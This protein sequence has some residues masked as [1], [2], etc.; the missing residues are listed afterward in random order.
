MRAE[1]KHKV[2][3]N[4]THMFIYGMHGCDG[5]CGLGGDFDCRSHDIFIKDFAAPAALCG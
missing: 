1:D 5:S 2:T 3:L 4:D